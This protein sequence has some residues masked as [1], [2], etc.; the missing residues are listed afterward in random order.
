M[1]LEAVLNSSASGLDSVSRRIA[2][3]SQNVANAGTVGYVRETVAVNSVAAAGQ[4][5][6]RHP[7]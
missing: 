7:P 1:S 6:T 2:T 5:L 3:V 4:S